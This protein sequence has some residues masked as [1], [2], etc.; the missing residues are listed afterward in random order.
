M[1]VLDFFIVAVAGYLLG[2]IPFAVI[3]A[4]ICGVDIFKFGSGNP[5]A[6]NVKRACG[7]KAGNV[8]FILDALKGFVAAGWPLWAHFIG[9]NFETP[10]YLTYV[11]LVAAIVGHSFSVF[12]RFRGG[13][14]V[15][16]AIGGLCAVMF[17]A[18]LAALVVWVIVF[19]AS[20][21]VS[22][23]S[24]SM[25][26]ALPVAAALIYGYPNLHVY[27]AIVLAVLIIFRHRSNIVRLMKGTE[28]RFDR[29]K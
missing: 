24:I 26:A 13:K 23:A 8:C 14:G 10:A 11:G 21:Y 12:I 22:L 18:V 1:N 4:R 15:S 2:A 6:T 16:T 19:Y 9:V 17:Y 20:R 25:A 5:G 29:K 28:N 7:K 27:V 3:I